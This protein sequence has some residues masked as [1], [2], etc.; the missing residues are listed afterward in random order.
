MFGKLNKQVI[1]SGLVLVFLAIGAFFMVNVNLP[2]WSHYLSGLN[3]VLFAVP[4]FWA[5][6][7]WLGW[8]DGAILLAALAAYALVIEASAII[9][10]FP[11]GHFGYSDLLGYRILGLVPWTIAFAWAPLILGA[12]AVASNLFGTVV[13]RVIAT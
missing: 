5:V 2:L 13:T 4:T 11:Y 7:W 12:Y 3:V 10:G 9:T 8:R 1:Y 6:R